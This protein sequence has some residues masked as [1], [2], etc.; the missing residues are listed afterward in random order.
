M[1]QKPILITGVHRSGSTWVGEMVGKSDE[2]CYIFEPF[3][4]NFGPGICRETFDTWY[5]YVTEENR[6]KYHGCISETL[7]FRFHPWK[8]LRAIKTKAQVRLWVQNFTRFRNARKN[9]PRALFKDPIAFFSAEWLAREFGFQVVVLIRH[10]AAFASS[11]KRLKWDFPF[12][13]LL[14]QPLLMEGPLSPFR[15]EIEKA[16]LSP[17]DIVDQAALL[18]KVIYSRVPHYQKQYPHWIFIRH[19]DISRDPTGRFESLFRSLG[20]TFTPAV[21]EHILAHSAGSNPKDTPEGKATFLKRNSK[22]NIY[23]WKK[24]LTHREIERVRE[25][26]REAAAPFYRDSEW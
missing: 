22:E 12:N 6:E 7:A 15:T 9:R 17:P 8:E 19:E 20:L 26:V 5:P 13:D 16:A 18:W 10:P 3:N 14:K 24:R 2:V 1:N 11:L 21:R 4:K 25:C 23:S